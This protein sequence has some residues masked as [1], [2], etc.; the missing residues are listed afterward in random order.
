MKGH[1]IMNISIHKAL[2]GLDS[3]CCF[4]DSSLLAFQ[5]TRPSRASTIVRRPYL[6]ILFRFQS[7]RPSRASTWCVSSWVRVPLFQSTRPSR[8]STLCLGMMTDIRPISIHKALAGLDL[9]VLPPWRS[10]VLF[11]STRPSR[12][13]TMWITSFLVK[14]FISIHKAL[15]GLDR[16]RT[17]RHR[18]NR[19]FNPQGPRGPRRDWEGIGQLIGQFQS[20]RPSRASTMRG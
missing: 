6:A 8:A 12:A 13:S 9:R 19:Y 11:Q 16:S 7:T 15:A 14:Y 20:T 4:K 5:S 1:F 18:S 2:A 10:G 17:Y 3:F